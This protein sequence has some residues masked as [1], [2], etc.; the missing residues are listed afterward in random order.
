[1]GTF[2]CFGKVVTNPFLKVFI[3]VYLI[4]FVLIALVLSPILIPTHLILRRN[5]KNGFFYNGILGIGKESFKKYQ[6]EIE[7]YPGSN[8]PIFFQ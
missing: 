6:P 4:M 8:I 2:K 3:V 1:M 7:C 5:G